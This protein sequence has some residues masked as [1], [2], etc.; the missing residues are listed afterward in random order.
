MSNE[1]NFYYRID[2]KNISKI[3]EQVYKLVEQKRQNNQDEQIN[4]ISNVCIDPTLGNISYELMPSNEI[5]IS[6]SLSETNFLILKYYVYLIDETNNENKSL[7]FTKSDLE[8]AFKSLSPSHYFIIDGNI[9]D[10][11]NKIIKLNPKIIILK[12]KLDNEISLEIF[13]SLNNKQNIPS[14][15]SITIDTNNLISQ[16]IN[17]LRIY[18]DK[19][20]SLVIKKRN[21]LINEIKYF[22]NN[23]EEKIMKIYGVDGIGKSLTFIY[24]T[25]L[26]NNFKIIYFNLKEFYLKNYS[27]LIN[28]FKYQLTNYYTL[29]KDDLNKYKIKKDIIDKNT[30]DD[31]SESMKIFNN[32]IKY[33]NKVD[34]WY[35]LDIF[36]NMISKNYSYKVLLIIDQYKIENDLENKLAILERNIIDGICNIK[37][38]IISSINDM[39]VKNDFIELL[40]NYLEPESNKTI[41]K[42]EN[43]LDDISFEDEQLEDIFR[44]FPKDKEGNGNNEEDFEKIKKFNIISEDNKYMSIENKKEKKEDI[45]IPENIFINQIESYYNKNKINL[46][47]FNHNKK[48]RIIYLNDL[49]SIENLNDE[50]EEIKKKMKAFNYN[51]KYYNKFKTHL[52]LKK[53]NINEAYNDFLQEQFGNIRNKI[54]KF[55]DDFTKKFN[56]ELNNRDIG[57]MLIQLKNIVEN[58]IELNFVSLIH[59]LNKFPIKYLKIIKVDDI[60]NNNFLRINQEISNFK[61]R[62]EYIFPFIKI[63]INRLLF[64]YGD[65]RDIKCSDLPPSGIGNFFEKQIRKGIIIK[66]IFNSFQSRNVWTFTKSIYKK[67]SQNTKNIKKKDQKKGKKKTVEMKEKKKNLGSTENELNKEYKNSEESEENKESEENEENNENQENIENQEYIENQKNE[68]QKN[69]IQENMKYKIDEEHKTNK[70]NEKII[71]KVEKDKEEEIMTELDFFNLKE[72]IYDDQIANPLINYNINYYIT[73]HRSNNPLIDSVIIIPCSTDN[74]IDKNF[75]LLGIQITINKWNIYTLEEYHQATEMAAIVMKSIYNINIKNKYFS[76]ILSKEYE[77]S[78]TQD[79]LR[80]MG[81]PFVFF[82][83]SE[84]CFY[85]ENKK[86]IKEINQFLSMQ[87]KLSSGKDRAFYYKNNMFKNME[88]LLQKKRSRDK[89]FQINNYAF[90]FIRKKLFNEEAELILTTNIKSEI[91]DIITNSPH[92]KNKVITLKYIFRIK[93]SEYEDLISCDNDYLL[94]ICFFKKQIFLFNKNLGSRIRIVSKDKKDGK[95][96]NEILNYINNNIEL[97][98]KDDKNYKENVPTIDKII[99]SYINKPSQIYVFAIYEIDK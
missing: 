32:K 76:F 30:F 85:F 86:E 18:R 99:L 54:L 61:F 60:E 52:Y 71:T 10:D 58:K 87:F 28:I 77:N 6:F 47:K 62:L 14:S 65:N 92:F 22:M 46:N 78:K 89:S 15:D 51:P 91:I 1:E 44:E 74:Q 9:I 81:I 84:N 80:K 45:D 38:L 66:K 48:Y 34:F 21:E 94:G 82:S 83:T 17:S 23:G 13:E 24:L 5:K 64:E 31:Y 43:I 33:E 90:N 56:I 50:K 67:S 73:C 88:D 72:L 57:L 97:E 93:F 37:L 19:I 42:L 26:I 25:S 55:Y 39:K 4:K 35:L 2:G 70:E 20:I 69:T 40:K 27:E 7:I 59:Y 29:E 53:E 49:I 12:K 75:N 16:N 95:V 3:I 41:Q 96:L 36:V 63:T 11:I 98:E 68:E 8:N 79:N